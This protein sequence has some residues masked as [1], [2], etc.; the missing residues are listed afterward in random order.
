VIERTDYTPNEVL[1]LTLP[2]IELLLGIDPVR[3]T[4][5]RKL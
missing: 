3:R 2:E 5:Q 1:E 4:M